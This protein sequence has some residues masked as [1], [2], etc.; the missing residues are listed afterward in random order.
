MIHNPCHVKLIFA[1]D[2]VPA[3]YVCYMQPY[4]QVLY[5]Y[6][7]VAVTYIDGCNFFPTSKKC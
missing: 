3:L 5:H 7:T 6:T 4:E 1:D 2:N